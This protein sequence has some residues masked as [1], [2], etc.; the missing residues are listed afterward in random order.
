MNTAVVP[1]TRQSSR[2]VPISNNK[3]FQRL[4]L[5]SLDEQMCK[6]DTMLP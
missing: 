1:S 2:L 5:A 6:T 3:L 4:A